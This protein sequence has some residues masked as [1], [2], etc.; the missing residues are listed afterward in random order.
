MLA[1]AAFRNSEKASRF[2]RF[3]VEHTLNGESGQLKEYRI[4]VDVFGRHSS[5]DP[6]LDPIV[7]LEARRVRAKLLQYY[8]ADGLRDA[9]RIDI[10]K[11]GY[12]AVFNPAAQPE[13]SSV[14]ARVQLAVPR[15]GGPK[16]AWRFGRHAGR[17][18]AILLLGLV[19][20]AA[21]GACW[22]YF[23]PASVPTEPRSIAVLPFSN[24]TGS[25]DNEWLSD[26]LTDDLAASLAKLPGTRIAARAS[27]FKFKG[28][29]PDARAIGKQLNASF[30]LDGS[31]QSTGGQ[32][33]VS[34]RFV[35]ANDGHTIWSK[36]YPAQSLGTFGVETKISKAVGA[37]LGIE[38]L[39][40]PDETSGHH[41]P[42][43]R[44]HELYILGRY[45]WNRRTAPNEW[46]AVDYFNQAL[47][48]DPL[49]PQ[50]YLGLADAYAVMGSNEYAPASDVYPKARAA[51]QQALA[52]DNT[53]GEAHATLAQVTYCFDWDLASAEREYKRAIQL[54]PSYAPAHQWYGL[55]LATER[56]FKDAT[57]EMEEAQQLDPLSL[58]IAVDLGQIY[59]FSG[60]EGAALEQGRKNL[61]YDASYAGTYQLLGLAYMWKG[62]YREAVE[63][64]RKY[65]TL[66]GNDS[67]ALSDLGV[68]YANSGQRKA[69]L[70]VLHQLEA[71]RATFA[72]AYAIAAVEAALGNKDDAYN[73]LRTAV[74]QHSPSCLML[75]LDPAFDSL[76]REPRFLALLK[77]VFKS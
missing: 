61:A 59:A 60:Q 58:V 15:A 41:V 43:Q 63:E 3:V 76:R 57:R 2:L 35:R 44:A 22:R 7:R 38:A 32:F 25:S 20:V 12:A 73:Q 50:A 9:I 68:V 64:F 48:Q 14:G 45:W 42:N 8:A 27:T 37:A 51:A 69:A 11:G 71:P 52:L 36:T 30:I 6:R 47:K 34:A 18:I 23:Q 33:K 29:T 74:A 65:T 40:E 54:N 77:L 24:L 4:G 10:P 16:E 28:A 17:Y 13:A 66:A 39:A 72:S 53:L 19:A 31:V 56:R 75:P 5:Y 55:M 26:G 1:S 67:E 21:A 62:S 70:A 46:K 49:Y